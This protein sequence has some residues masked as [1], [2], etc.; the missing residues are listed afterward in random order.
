MNYMDFDPGLTKERHQNM[1]RELDSM[2]LHKRL[3]DE[4]TSSG[5]R[6]VA[7]ARRSVRPLMRSRNRGDTSKVAPRH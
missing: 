7:L 4:R 3:R 1:L 6:L 2:R 5:S